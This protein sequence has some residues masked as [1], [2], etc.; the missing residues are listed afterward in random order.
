MHVRCDIS[1][2]PSIIRYLKP[3][4]SDVFIARFVDYHFNESVFSPLGG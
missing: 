1:D 4:T 2:S 3:L